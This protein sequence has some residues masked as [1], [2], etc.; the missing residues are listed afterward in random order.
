MLHAVHEPAK[1]GVR[2]R[3]TPAPSSVSYRRQVDEQQRLDG[4]P[5]SE[6]ANGANFALADGSVTFYER[7][8]G[9]GAFSLMGSM[10]DG[11]AA[12]LVERVDRSRFGCGG[13]LTVAKAEGESYSQIGGR[14]PRLPPLFVRRPKCRRG[15]LPRWSEH[16]EN[17]SCPAAQFVAYASG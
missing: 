10:A 16:L 3:G 4:S 6:H 1:C 9:S 8:D 2:H 5:G 12:Q 15:I 13:G 11:M 17:P 7:L 14:R